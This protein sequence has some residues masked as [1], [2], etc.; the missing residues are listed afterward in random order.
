MSSKIKEA[1][2]DLKEKI[3]E[4]VKGHPL[5]ALATIA[6]DGRP[7]VRYIMLAVERDLCIR[8]VTSLTSRK[9]AQINR[10]PEV[11][12][13]C[14]A[15]PED[16][17]APYVQVEGKAKISCD[18]EIRK[19]MWTSVLN[20]YF[21]GPDDPDYGVVIIEPSGSNITAPRGHRRSGLLRRDDRICLPRR[22]PYKPGPIPR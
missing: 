5:G 10:N 3:Y 22:Y 21:S 16:S 14:G 4:V 6:E 17:M 8:F 2:M 19:K 7:R 15:S 1:Q 9:V 11:H 18:E 12:V 20:N 13:I